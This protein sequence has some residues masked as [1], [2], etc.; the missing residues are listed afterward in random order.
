MK[1][2]HTKTQHFIN[3]ENH[4]KTKHRNKEKDTLQKNIKAEAMLFVLHSCFIDNNKKM[5][6]LMYCNG[7]KENTRRQNT[8][9]HQLTGGGVVSPGG[10]SGV[11][12]TTVVVCVVVSGTGGLV[13]GGHSGTDGTLAS[14]DSGLS[15]VSTT[16]TVVV[17]QFVAL[18]DD[19]VVGLSYSSSELL[20]ELFSSRFPTFYKC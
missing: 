9:H 1:H 8:H 11:A 5:Y 4:L 6:L 10:N 3:Y 12:V 16:F 19:S 20:S 17:A 14:V 7:R 18:T 13:I 2:M 15:V